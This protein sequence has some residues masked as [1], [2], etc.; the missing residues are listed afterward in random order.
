MRVQ[1]DEA[2]HERGEPEVAHRLVGMQ[3]AQMLEVADLDDLVVADQHGAVLDV[4]RRDRHDVARCE[5]HGFLRDRGLSAIL[6]Q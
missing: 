1:V 4:R 2:G 5:Q 3:R 6:P